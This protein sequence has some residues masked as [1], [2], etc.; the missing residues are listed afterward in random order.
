[1]NK[2]PV[3][4]TMQHKCHTYK[5][6]YTSRRCGG[7][8]NTTYPHL[9]DSINKSPVWG[10]MQ[11]QCHTTRYTSRRCGVLCN[12]TY[13]HLQDSVNKSPVWGTMQHQCHYI[14][15][16][17]RQVAGMGDYAT[18]MPHLY[19]TRYTSHRCGGLCNTTYPHLQDSMNKSPVWGTMQHQCHTYKTR[20][21]SRRCGGPCN[22]NATPTRLDTQVASVV[23]YKH[24][25]HYIPSPVWRTIQHQCH[26]I[27]TPT[28]LDKP[29]TGGGTMQHY[30]HTPTRLTPVWGSMQHQS[31]TYKTRYTSCRC[32]GLCNT[33]ATPTRLDE[34]VASMGDYATLMPLHTHLQDSLNK[35]LGWTTR[36]INAITYPH[37]QDSTNYVDDVVD[38]KDQ[39]TY[40]PTFTRLDKLITNEGDYT[41][42]Y[43]YKIRSDLGQYNLT[44]KNPRVTDPKQ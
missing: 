27:P 1:M 32:G 2:S 31:H 29:V 12:T 11:H 25:C 21:T 24:Q 26:Y 22:T 6:R 13:P 17:A 40:V 9:Q 43:L 35:S 14:P 37:L 15:T 19:K 44:I 8:C 33:N 20:L 34:Q 23:E 36:N 42:P 30:I 18:Q 4:G 7:L 38:Y 16:P 10:T 5:T 3:W 28:R 39:C 41:D